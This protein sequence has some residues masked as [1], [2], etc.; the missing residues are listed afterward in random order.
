MNNNIE[1]IR[2]NI[3]Y[4]HSLLLTLLSDARTNTQAQAIEKARVRLTKFEVA[5]KQVR[6]VFEE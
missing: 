2:E 4:T 3:K 5:V 6:E 1:Q